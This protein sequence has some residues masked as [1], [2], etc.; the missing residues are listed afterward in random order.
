[1]EDVRPRFLPGVPWLSNFPELNL[2][3]Y[4]THDGKPGLWFFSLDAHNPVAVRLARASFGLPYFDARMSFGVSGEEVRYRSVRTHKRALP[5]MFVGRYRPVGERFDS[6]PGTLENFL[7]ERYCLY[8][9]GVNQ[10][11]QVRRGDIHHVV[12]P[13]QGAEAEVE[14]LQMTAQI[15][16]ELPETEPILHYAGR[17]DVVAWPPKRIDS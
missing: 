6:Q 4:V 14:E 12:W 9:A 15:G 13:L 11:R 2:R 8:S 5:A 17:L 7:T 1:M 3:T 16:V 10:E